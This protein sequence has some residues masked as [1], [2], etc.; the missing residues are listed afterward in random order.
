[1]VLWVFF[2]FFQI[3]DH[4][5]FEYYG[6]SFQV[7][8]VAQAEAIV[9]A[10]VAAAGPSSITSHLE[11][12]SEKKEEGSRPPTDASRVLHDSIPAPESVTSETAS[13]KL[14]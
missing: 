2:C 9:D 3:T 12:N 8:T 1:M 11:T 7:T 10:S 4:G 14:V 5:Y 13:G 6:Q